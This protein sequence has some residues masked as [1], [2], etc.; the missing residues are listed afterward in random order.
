MSGTFSSL[1]LQGYVEEF[2]LQF[3]TSVNIHKYVH[4]YVREVLSLKAEFPKTGDIGQE[5]RK[6]S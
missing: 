4:T 3:R 2:M 5:L 1:M 6:L